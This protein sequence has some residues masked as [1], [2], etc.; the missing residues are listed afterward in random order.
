MEPSEYPTNVIS[1]NN[2]A[3]ISYEYV[4]SQATSPGSARKQLQKVEAR[5]RQDGRLV[6]YD[7]YR[8]GIWI[9]RRVTVPNGS[10]TKESEFSNMSVESQGLG[11]VRREMGTYEPASLARSKQHSGNSMSAGSAS[12]SP[13]SSLDA[14]LRNAQIFNAKSIQ[15]NANLNMMQEPSASSPGAKLESMTSPKDINEYFISA[16]LSSVVYFLCHD[17]DFIPLNSR[18][19]ILAAPRS[20]AKPGREIE[21]A[22]LDISLTSLG[23]LVI[24]AHSDMASGLQTLRDVFGATST[25][26]GLSPGTAL[27]LA[28][29]GSAA[30]FHSM[31]DDKSLPENLSIAQLQATSSVMK[32]QGVLNPLTIR[33]WQSRCLKWLAAKGLNPVSLEAGGWIY[34]QIVGGLLPY[35]NSDSSGIP[36]LEELAIVPWPAVLCFQ[37]SSSSNMRDSQVESVADCRDPLSFAE[38]WFTSKDERAAVISNRLKEKL[39]ADALLNEHADGEIRALQSH[40]Y[41]P[42]ALRRGSNVGAM[43]PTPPDAPQ[44]HV[45][46]TP[47]FDGNL[48]TPGN[49]NHSVGHEAVGALPTNPNMMDVDADLWGSSGKKDRTNSAVQYHDDNDNN[50]EN[51]NANLFGDLGGDIFGTHITDDDFNFFDEPDDDFDQKPQLTV[52][53][54]GEPSIVEVKSGRHSSSADINDKD[55]TE[56]RVDMGH[57]QGPRPT[58]SKTVDT[59]ENSQV[60]IETVQHPQPSI[61]L[62]F[63][64][65]I[66]FQRLVQNPAFSTVN[67]QPRRTSLFRNIHFEESLQSVNEKYGSN[68]QFNFSDDV[69]YRNTGD[70]AGLPQTRYLTSRRKAHE[71]TQEMGTI[72]RMLGEK[73]LDG[74]CVLVDDPMDYLMTSDGGSPI[75]EQDDSS[76]TT[77]DG[78]GESR[79]GLKRKWEGLEEDD[80]ASTFDNLAMEFEQSVGTPQSMSGSQLP[81]LDADPADWALTSY[82]TSPEPDVD[83]EPNSLTD[84]ERIATAQ[85]LA[86]QAVSGTLRLPGLSPNDACVS[87]DRTSAT[88]QLLN[89]LAK[90]VSSCLHDG[91]ICPMRNYLDIQGIPVLSQA[92][93][94]PPRPAPNPRNSSNLDSRTNNPFLIIPPQIEV[95]RSETK[96]SILPSSVPFW[97]NLGLGPSKG[98]KDIDAVCVYPSF[99][100]VAAHAST[101]LDQMRSVYESSRFGNH[102]KVNSNDIGNGL[103]PFGID[104]TSQNKVHH[105]TVLKETAARLSRTLSSL[106][107]GERNYVIY[108]VYP[109]DNSILLHICSAFQHLFNLYRKA[110]AERRAN[111]A[112][113]LVLQLIPL[114]FIA[115]PTSLAVPTPSTYFQLCMEVYDRCVDFKSSSSSPAIML[116]QPLP[117]TIDFKLNPSPSASV[118]QENTCLHVAYAQSIDDRW[119]TAAWTDNRGTRQMTAS[120]CLGRKNEPISTTFTEVANEI[121]ETTLQV[122][123]SHKIHWRIMIARVGVMDSSEIDFWTGLVS[124]ESNFQIALTLVTVQTDPSLRLLPAWITLTPNGSGAQPVITPVSTPQA[125]QSSI[126]SPETGTTPIRENFGAATFAETP[127]ELDRDSRLIDYTDQNWGAVLSHRLNNSNSLLESN[128]ALISGYLI[129]R[130]GANATDPP[131]VMEVNIV[132]S[133]VL[134]NPRI[135]HE[136]LLRELL[137]YYRGLGTLARARGATDAVFDIRPWHIAAAEKA[138]K[139][140]YMLI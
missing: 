39:V 82:F 37:T 67:K 59:A 128:P 69:K 125:L 99:E 132:H 96:L 29:S 134:G 130:G 26:C 123:A 105:S 15:T 124:R 47:S 133:E 80:M 28:P 117:R 139:S 46:A 100:G 84:L 115:S 23:T 77:D 41:S 65:E 94:L 110:L 140:L 76:R 19:L 106:A 44:P 63:N 38:D 61:N 87:F 83:V 116:E 111:T 45:G 81:L 18:T 136:S 120:Y 9:F 8:E 4:E 5:W 78:I 118:L 24:K 51:D 10:P 71:G 70:H 104:T 107:V 74:Q 129:K 103:L 135:F 89:K 3:S 64:K 72:A 102:D 48:S 73:A 17:H 131:I 137:G 40:S 114:D 98:T 91:T 55:T 113:E 42:V 92:L 25:T 43:Y 53:V 112:N 93:R 62:P 16:V 7:P 138:V 121:W 2:F 79:F 6:H 20:S 27:W 50:N 101:F 14:T 56:I 13:S 97:E 108:F 30:K 126:L 86:D 11:V 32:S 88:K 90:A 95:R 57:D 85:I 75:S 68:G 31:P 109:V 34:V 119:I 49:P 127:A 22:T 36:L 21:L 54:M 58:T 12:S 122:V 35:A 66:I 52:Q 1:F 33:S 60:D